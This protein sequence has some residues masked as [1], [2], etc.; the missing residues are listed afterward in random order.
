MAK[1]MELKRRLT[2][3]KKQANQSMEAYLR[4]IKVIA[5]SLAAINAPLSDQE[6]MQYTIFGLDGD[7]DNLVTDAA[8]FGANLTRT[9][10]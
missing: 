2:N 4:E 3:M 6:L 5:D 8:Y 1:T 9:N 10:E 7:F